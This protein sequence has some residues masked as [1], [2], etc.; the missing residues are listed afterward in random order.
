MMATLVLSMASSTGRKAGAVKS[1]RF[2]WDRA[3]ALWLVLL[4]AHH[5]SQGLLEFSSGCE[6]ILDI[7]PED[8]PLRI[9]QISSR[10]FLAAY[11]SKRFP[12]EG[13]RIEARV[14]GEGVPAGDPLEWRTKRKRP[15]AVAIDS[16]RSCLVR[17]NCL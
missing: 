16:R 4:F 14:A 11:L 1:S 6:R 13:Q 15:G 10:Q 9:Q 2:S 17:A 3:P 8:F 5:R 12:V 7:E